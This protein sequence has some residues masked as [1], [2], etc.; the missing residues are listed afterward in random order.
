METAVHDVTKVFFDAIENP[1]E[2]KQEEEKDILVEQLSIDP[3]YT[4]YKEYIDQLIEGLTVLE[5]M[6]EKTDTPEMIGFRYMIARVAKYYLITVR[7]YPEAVAH[8]RRTGT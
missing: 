1:V 6:I 2:V 8:A 7:D 3:R 5:N 4:A